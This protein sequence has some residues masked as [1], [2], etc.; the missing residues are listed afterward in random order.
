MASSP[1]PTTMVSMAASRPSTIAGMESPSSSTATVTTASSS[2]TISAAN[3]ASLTGIPIE[4]RLM[5]FSY[6]VKSPTGIVSI[7]W[8]NTNHITLKRQV[9]VY[10]FTGHCSSTHICYFDGS[11]LFSLSFLRTCK[12]TYQE[13][14][15][16]FWEQN[17]FEITMLCPGRWVRNPLATR[18][19]LQLVEN[20]QVVW[21]RI[22]GQTNS[23]LKGDLEELK[24]LPVLKELVLFVD[25]R[26]SHRALGEIM[27]DDF[28]KRPLSSSAAMDYQET[29]DTLKHGSGQLSHLK[30]NV[31]FS[32]SKTVIQRK[33]KFDYDQG[34]PKCFTKE[35]WK[36]ALVVF[37]QVGTAFRCQV[38]LDGKVVSADGTSHFKRMSFGIHQLDVY[39]PYQRYFYSWIASMEFDCMKIESINRMARCW[40][41]GR[42][43]VF[44]RLDFDTTK[45]ILL[46]FFTSGEAVE[47]FREWLAIVDER[48]PP[49]TI[50]RRVV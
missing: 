8:D 31:V 7:A 17:A 45:D 36:L 20:I 9:C 40:L 47:M 48:D 43:W 3:T 19:Y 23:M 26:L 50:R 46:D 34:R 44:T 2:S 29:L 13:C 10:S 12:I 38:W 18:S 5:I 42:R 22:G 21:L 1:P 27:G 14:R 11:R 16:I 6:L 37:E 28:R 41:E 39:E 15:N 24:T 30:R 4:T 33:H 49:I 25:G 32:I 35:D